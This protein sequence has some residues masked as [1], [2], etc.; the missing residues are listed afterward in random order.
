MSE[1]REKLPG[2]A[3]EKSQSD[4]LETEDNDVEAHRMDE[5]GQAGEKGV[6][7]DDNG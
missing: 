6:I 2:D 7:A 1:D 3:G 5:D 4:E